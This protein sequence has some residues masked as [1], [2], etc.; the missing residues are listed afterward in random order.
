MSN[1]PDL[2]YVCGF[3]SESE[4]L[5]EDLAP[6]IPTAAVEGLNMRQVTNIP[7]RTRN[8][9]S[10]ATVH[11]FQRCRKNIG[12]AADTTNVNGSLDIRRPD[13]QSKCATESRSAYCMT[14][15]PQ[16]AIKGSVR[17]RPSWAIG[18]TGRI[19]AT[20]SRKSIRLHIRAI[21]IRA[22]SS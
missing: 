13:N 10:S 12:T 17:N 18:A 9:S 5:P 11:S 16:Y 15:R 21:M 20:S 19:R 1:P 8:Q 6:T 4:I 2:P 7:P 3:I 14:S 22:T